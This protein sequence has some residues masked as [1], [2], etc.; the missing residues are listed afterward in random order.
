MF[1]ATALEGRA[2]VTDMLLCVIAHVPAHR[3]GSCTAWLLLLSHHVVRAEMGDGR[4]RDLTPSPS[5]SQRTKHPSVGQP[6]LLR[7]PAS[8]CVKV[9]RYESH[10]DMS[11]ARREIRRKENHCGRA[12]KSRY[13]RAML[14]VGS[15]CSLDGSDTAVILGSGYGTCPCVANQEQEFSSPFRTMSCRGT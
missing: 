4:G 7:M 13:I 3:F 5:P 15:F 9:G 6:R 12:L 8:C 1:S 10:T 2:Q 14:R 11:H